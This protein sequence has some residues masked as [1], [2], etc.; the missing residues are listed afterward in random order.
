MRAGG[1][2]VRDWAT[3]EQAPL[4]VSPAWEDADDP[5]LYVLD[6]FNP[7]TRAYVWRQLAANYVANGVR[8][9]WLDEAEPER[10]LA[11]I[12]R[13]YL[14]H[15]GTDAEVGLGWSRAEQQMV[16]EGGCRRWYA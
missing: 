3:G 13:R 7:A 2:L 11:D 16:Y 1:L 12:G 4:M 5:A 8:L 9:F 15:A 14:Y 6:P 10:H